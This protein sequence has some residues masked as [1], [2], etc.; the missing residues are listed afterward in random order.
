ML[1]IIVNVGDRG[2]ICRDGGEARHDVAAIEGTSSI[3]FLR[4]SQREKS[5]ERYSIQRRGRGEWIGGGAGAEGRRRKRGE[6]RQAK[7][8]SYVICT[9][10][11]KELDGALEGTARAA[12]FRKHSSE[13]I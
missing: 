9:I 4:K 11:L 2:W 7:Q 3:G 8:Q 12:D 10:A 6:R 13:P 5:L 1:D